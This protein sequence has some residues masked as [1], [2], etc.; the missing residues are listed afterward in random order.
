MRHKEAAAMP[1]QPEKQSSGN[2]YEFSS[3]EIPPQPL[4]R[5]G[6]HFESSVVPFNDICVLF[7]AIRKSNIAL[8][9]WIVDATAEKSTLLADLL[10]NLGAWGFEA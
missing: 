9:G 3:P 6:D 8:M 4:C 2:D 1:L 7:K 10:Q 5:G